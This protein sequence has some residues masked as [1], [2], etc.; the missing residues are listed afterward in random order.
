MVMKTLILVASALVVLGTFAFLLARQGGDEK[1]TPKE[2]E[3]QIPINVTVRDIFTTD[4]LTSRMTPLGYRWLMIYI[5][6]ENLGDLTLT[7]FDLYI[8][9]ETNLGSEDIETLTEYINNSF[10]FNEVTPGGWVEGW[11]AFT[12]QY[13]EK[14]FRLS[15]EAGPYN[16][17]TVE[18]GLPDNIEFRPWRSPAR[19]EILGCGRENGTEREKYLYMDIKVTNIGENV[20]HFE[21]WHLTLNCTSGTVLDAIEVPQPPDTT[22]YPGEVEYYRLFFDIPPGSP[23]LPETLVDDLDGLY[24]V[25]DPSLYQGLI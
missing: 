5:E 20:T 9:L 8:T 13:H 15:V 4:R 3:M 21:A 11:G 22:L 1:G 24:I 19:I 18:V 25:V 2:K 16:R 17:T 10:F 7:F 23:D 14:P 12:L 6:M